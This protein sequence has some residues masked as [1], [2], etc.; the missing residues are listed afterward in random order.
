VGVKGGSVLE[1]ANLVLSLSARLDSD[2]ESG[3]CTGRWTDTVAVGL[4]T[5]STQLE[6]RSRYEIQ[7]RDGP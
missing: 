2:M 6:L 4:L 7:D 3:G 1:W 5:Y